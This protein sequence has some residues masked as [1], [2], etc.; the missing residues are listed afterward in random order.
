MPP[1]F[2]VGQ[3]LWADLPYRTP[4]GHEQHG[5]RPVVVVAV[6]E[7]VQPIPYRMLVVVPLTRTKIQGPLFPVLNSG[8]AGLPAESTALMYQVTALD[9]SR[10][11]GRIGI[12]TDVEY[13]P[14]RAAL[15]VLFKQ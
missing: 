10:V 3:I 12:L 6:P 4:A 14:I 7:L 5:R 2:T 1:R 8:V 15:Q 13:E 9:A 11:Q